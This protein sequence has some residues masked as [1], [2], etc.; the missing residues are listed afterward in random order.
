[1][2]IHRIN[3]DG[4]IPQDNP[5]LS[6]T[7]AIPSIY[8]Y[9]SRNSQ[10]LAFH[11]ETGDLWSTEHGQ[12]GGDELNIIRPGNNYG[13]DV[14]TYGRNYDG[15]VSTE[16][17]KMEGMEVPI[18]VW[19]PSIAVCGLDF[20]TGDLFPRWKGHLLVGALKFEEVRILDIEDERVILQ[21]TLIK[22]HGRVRDVCTGPDGAIYVVVNEPG[23]VLRLSPK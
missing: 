23:K 13:W 22:N 12:K 15:T 14:I 17:V 5:F 3:R 2:K 10:G 7:I 20:Y 6:N 21:E 9:G 18:L 19:R 8:A 11:P 4:T 16:E 1:G